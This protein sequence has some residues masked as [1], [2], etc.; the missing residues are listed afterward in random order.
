MLRVFQKVF[1]GGGRQKFL[2]LEGVHGCAILTN[3]A[4][5]EWTTLFEQNIIWVNLEQKIKQA[6]GGSRCSCRKGLMY[7]TLNMKIQAVFLSIYMTFITI[8]LFRNWIQI[9][10]GLIL[11]NQ[12]SRY[13]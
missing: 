3:Q 1:R 7:N 10:Y 5:Y 13:K 9:D 12:L 6:M 11:L 2:H 4:Y 8:N